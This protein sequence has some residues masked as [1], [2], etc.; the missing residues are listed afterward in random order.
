MVCPGPAEENPTE[1]SAWAS[2]AALCRREA[3]RWAYSSTPNPPSPYCP[4]RPCNWFLFSDVLKRLKLSSRI[5]QARFPHFE[6]ATLPKAEFQRQVSLSQVLAQE[7]VQESPEPAQGAAETVGAGAL[8]QAVG[9]TL[10]LLPA[11]RHLLLHWCW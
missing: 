1:N 11:H 7:E 5:F 3:V 10:L 6:I 8:R 4:C 2:S 9:E